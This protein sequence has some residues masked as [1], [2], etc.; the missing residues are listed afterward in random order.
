M[1][2]QIWKMEY[3]ILILTDYVLVWEDILLSS[4]S[5]YFTCKVSNK[6]LKRCTVC[7]KLQ[8]TTFLSQSHIKGFITV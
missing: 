1:Q 6:T 8:I 5:G 4:R 3:G 7:D 2:I